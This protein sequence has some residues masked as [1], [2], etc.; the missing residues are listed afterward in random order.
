MSTSL[1]LQSWGR[2]IKSSRLHSEIQS[3]NKDNYNNNKDIEKEVT[4]SC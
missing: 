4:E 1:A 3:Q 2:R